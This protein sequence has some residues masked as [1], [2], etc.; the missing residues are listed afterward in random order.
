M[1]S[2]HFSAAKLH[3]LNDYC[4]LK[5]IIFLY[6]NFKNFQVSALYMAPNHRTKQLTSRL[7]Y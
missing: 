5:Q 1:A 2:Y 7:K 4:T 3:F 6:F